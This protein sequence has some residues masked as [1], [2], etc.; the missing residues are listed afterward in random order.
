MDDPKE[1]TLEVDNIVLG[2]TDDL[3]AESEEE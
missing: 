2:V 1:V 3:G